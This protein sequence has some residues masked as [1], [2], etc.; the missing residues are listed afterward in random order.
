VS[1][2]AIPAIGV[3]LSPLPILAMLLVLGGGRPTAAGSAF[4]LAWTAG[5]AVPTIA[6]VVAA[7]RA[8]ATDGESRAI[9]A[10]EIAVGVAFLVVAIRLALA[11][12]RVR[13]DTAP[14]WLEALDRSGPRRAAILG[15]ML[16]AGNPKNLALMLTAAVAIAQGSEGNGQLTFSTVAFVALAVSTVS[17]LLAGRVARPNRSGRALSRMRGTLGRHDRAFAMALAFAIGAFFLLDGLR[18]L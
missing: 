9:A 13:S 3:A 7:E 17:L 2:W 8:G 14:P 6:F 11:P 1:E 16:S 10:G 18:G 12:R 15:V 5:V 4:W